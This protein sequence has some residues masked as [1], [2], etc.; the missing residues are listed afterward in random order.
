MTVWNRVHAQHEQSRQD[1]KG[2][3]M[4]R[5]ANLKPGAVSSFAVSQG[6]PAC[7]WHVGIRFTDMNGCNIAVWQLVRED[8][9][10]YDA[11]FRDGLI[12]RELCPDDWTR[13]QYLSVRDEVSAMERNRLG[14]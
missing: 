6:W 13:H 12:I 14:L 9:A 10:V 1:R 2:C 5:N 7:R 8:G 11:T 3:D 4:L